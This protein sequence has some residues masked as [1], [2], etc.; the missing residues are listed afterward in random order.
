MTRAAKDCD[1][2]LQ[3]ARGLDAAGR[4]LEAAV[5][6]GELLKGPKHL[7]A[8]QS[9]GRISFENGDLQAAQH[10]FGEAVELAPD[11]VEGFH[12]RGV[13]LMRLGHN[14]EALACLERAVALDPDFTEAILNH[15]TVLS[16]MKRPNE[17]LACFDRLLALDPNSAV[18]WNNRGNA[19]VALGRLEEA[20][21]A[22][23]RAIAIDPDF[24]EAKRN[25]FYALLALRKVDRISDFAV[26]E[27][28][29]AVAARY[30]QTVLQALDYRGHMHLQTLAL[31]V[32]GPLVAPWC[33]LDLGCGTG[34]AGECFKEAARGGRL[35]GVDIS[36]AM[37][38]EARK[39]QIYDH[40]IVADFEAFLAAPGPS[41]RLILSADAIVYI[42]DL[43]PAF[44]G[45][46]S[47]LE[48]AGTFLFTCEAKQGDGWELTP[49]NRFRHSESY[50]RA[51]AARAGLLWLDLMECTPR[52]E[53]GE[54]V[55]GLAVALRK[56]PHAK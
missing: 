40:L 3:E 33:I 2:L 9:L 25:R 46:A 5:L 27:A 10:F 26:R 1:R 41:Y 50:L 39:R 24:D 51:Q 28:F 4:R 6:Y 43:A 22:Y 30:D 37:I 54:P 38:E 34:L 7:E 11:F 31:R 15:A 55:Q 21:A 48:P 44:A 12:L 13:A 32:L 16:E 42:G 47:R 52:Y 29:D 56:N 18:A 45:V 8:L 49:A 20:T 19:L 17:A 14:A 35:D 23:D 53:G 36:P